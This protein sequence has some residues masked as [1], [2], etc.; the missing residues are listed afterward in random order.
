MVWKIILGC[1]ELSA[2]NKIYNLNNEILI[3]AMEILADS[4]IKYIN[5]T[6]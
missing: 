4:V 2:L 6:N 3:D 5:H 1:T